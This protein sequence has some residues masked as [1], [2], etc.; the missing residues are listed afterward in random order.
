MAFLVGHLW[1][2][3]YTPEDG[4]FWRLFYVP[5]SEDAVRYDR[6]TGY[7]SAS[8][9]AARGIEGL[10]RNGSRMR[11]LAGLQPG[12][13]G[14]RRDRAR[15]ENASVP[16][17][18]ARSAAVAAAWAPL[19][20]ALPGF[21]RAILPPVTPEESERAIEARPVPED[22]N[23]PQTANGLAPAAMS[24]LRV[25]G[26]TVPAAPASIAELARVLRNNP[27]L[28]C[29]YVRNNIEHYPVWGVQKGALGAL[30]DN[31]GTAFD[32]ATLMVSLLRQAGYT[33]SYIKGGINLTAAQIRDWLG[34]STANACAVVNLLAKGQ[35]PVA[36]ATATAGG[37]CPGLNAA[38]V[39][40]RLSHVWVKTMIGGTAYY[41]DPSFKPHTLKT[42]VNLA[43]ASG[44]NATTY[45]TQAKSGATQTADYIQ[46]V[47]RTN[48]RNNLTA[49][50][51][52]LANYLRTHQPAGTLDDAIGG[53]AIIP[54]AGG[55]LRQTSLPYQDTGVALTEWTDI[56][57]NYKPTLRIQYQGIDATYSSDAI[58]GKRLTITYNASNQP[59][60][61]LDGT[62]QA[63]GN[64]I[65]PGTGGQ[66]NFTVTHGAYAETFANQ[67]FTQEIKA[68]GTFLI[69]NGWGPAGRGPIELH[70]QRLEDAK[71]AGGA[72][73]SEP[74]L[75]SSLA[76]LSSTWIAQ[77]NASDYIGD[78]LAGTNTLFHHQIGIAGY[79]RGA[80]VDLPGN[81]LSV[82]SQTANAARESAAFFSAAMHASI[83]ESTAVQQTSSASAVSTVKLMD[84]AAANGNRI[85]DAKST[86]YYAVVQPSLVSCA[87]YLAS[88]QAAIN[89]GHRLILPD[90]C[91]LAENTWTGTGYFD[92]QVTTGGSGIFARISGGLA[93]GFPST[94]VSAP[95]VNTFSQ[96]SMPSQ[97]GSL[98][99]TFYNFFSDPI[100]MVKGN[101]VYEHQDFSVGVGEFPY[102]LGF[103]KL[104]S[105]GLRS[106]T[107]PLG[108]GW[109]HNFAITARVNSDGFQ[110]LGEDSALD[111][112]TSIVEQMVAFDLLSDTAKP[113]D[114]LVVATLGQRW[115]GDQLLNNT[116]IVRQ[117]LNG[118]VFVK[119]PDG[120]Y[121]PPPGNAARLI[122]NADTTFT[123]ETL[124]RDQLNFN[125]AG[126][127][128]TF[129]AASGV[130]VK[131]TYSGN[132]LTQVQNSLGWFLHLSHFNG[133][134]AEVSDHF[135]RVLYFY[136]G[137][138]NLTSF[139]ATSNAGPRPTTTFQYDQ[140][141][142]MTKLF[143]PSHPTIAFATNVY[144]SLG[145]VRT[146]TNA[147]SQLY[148]YYFAGSRSEEVDPLN[149]SKVSYFDAL[150][151]I[152]K[153]VTPAGRITLNTYDG[154]ER[155]TRTTLPEGNAVT[156]TYDDAPCA[157]AEKRCTHNLKTVTQVPK[158][159]SG[160]ANRVASYTY[161]SAF[162]RVQHA[163]DP[164]GNR[165]SYSYHYL[166]G[167]PF[168]VSR[169]EGSSTTYVNTPY[170]PA[171]F[172]TFYLPT[173][174]IERIS[175]N[176]SVVTTTTYNA[177]E[178]YVPQTVTVDS[179]DGKL[180]LTTR[181]TYSDVGNLVHID[182]PRA[183]VADTVSFFYDFERRPTWITD[184]LGK[185]TRI[186]YDR[187]GRPIRTAVLNGPQWRVS[188]RTYTPSGKLLKAWGPAQTTSD[189]TCPTAAAPVPVTDYAYDSLDRL[190]TITENLPAAEGGTRVTQTTYLADDRVSTVQRL[191]GTTLL[192][193]YASYTYTPNGLPATV[194][195]ARNNLTTYEYDG[196]DRTLRTRFPSPNTANSSSATDYEQYGYDAAGNLTSLRKRNGQSVTFGYD[197]LNRLLSRTYPNAADNASFSY[198]FQGR[199][200][201]ANY[202]AHAVSY[203][204][205]NGGR[206]D[207][208]PPVRRRRQPHPHPMAGGHPLLRHKDLRRPQPAH[209]HPGERQRPPRQLRLRRPVAAH[210]RDPGQRHHDHLRLRCPVG[211]RQPHPQPGRQRS[212][213]HLDLHPQP[214][215]GN[216]RPRLEQ[217]ALPVDRSHQR[218][219][220]LHRQRAE[221]VHCRRGRH[222]EL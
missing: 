34:V 185:S 151:K 180:N 208:H 44:Y 26:D 175:T 59:V 195:D 144:D 198:D 139:Q 30:L 188:C 61:S 123:Y 100:D 17:S 161:E 219:P 82:A 147:N 211:P 28:I 125:S 120:Q 87:A 97:S 95:T 140:P 158:A 133:R 194:K 159:G 36:G 132:D 150:G 3:E 9:L 110:G 18:K 166:A 76:V 2:R 85:Y 217:W 212:G 37:D 210:H 184:A 206:Q 117:G 157:A 68:G 197:N 160:L 88:F 130:Q 199:R 64:A 103:Q 177:A 11:L 138:D 50:S 101:F 126:Q 67:T 48:I 122:R 214:G 104:Y 23:Q 142:R 63:V 35:I 171:G 191:N 222:P 80:Y 172:P 218:H 98:S 200:T 74:V 203:A 46:G 52:N 53:M 83:F 45:L 114:K 112:V 5:A 84:I 181:Y 55:N 109:T 90:R 127:I 93:G 1:Q 129:Q 15:R 163:T 25:G 81:V 8:A 42:G 204:Y 57:G 196:H 136:D 118:E 137:S 169:P 174:V 86:N 141:G 149:G 13:G 201:A 69:G 209:R 182:G 116:V 7:F 170:T 207:P 183:D 162:N 221:P 94:L 20:D 192:Q 16:A 152:V 113:L 58:Y 91:N 111:A 193:T 66:V 146:Q 19:V 108:K 153:S 124:H 145:R 156:Y 70:R 75:G 29:E 167:L 143:Y 33:A 168:S 155:L 73:T 12:P 77:V 119:L 134:I 49:Y 205:D 186:A 78:R 220:Q 189:T 54:H 56:P 10:G 21:N 41:F 65:I 105:S 39:S 4:D 43:T 128:A 115:F 47:N 106:Q 173:R 178:R 148:T 165:T 79:D 6:L 24:A 213:Q 179:G 71:A 121:N 62:S 40:I 38:L 89:A 164:R 190:S 22:L 131:F 176:R 60:L 99:Q 154:Q 32:Q 202:A 92:T 187:D 135:R 31:Q 14:N 72:D 215:P 107:G 96:A 216:H 102:A 51:T 27:D